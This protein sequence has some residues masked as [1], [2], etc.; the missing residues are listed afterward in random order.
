MKNNETPCVFQYEAKDEDG[1]IVL[2]EGLTQE[3]PPMSAEELDQAAQDICR[4]I[5]VTKVAIRQLR[6]TEIN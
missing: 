2:M 6:I 5:G 3:Y 4:Q 1:E